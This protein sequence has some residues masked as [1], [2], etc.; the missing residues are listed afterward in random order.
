MHALRAISISVR[1]QAI[2]VLALVALWYW[3]LVLAL[4]NRD[5]GLLLYAMFWYLPFVS[6]IFAGTMLVSFYR[7][8]R[9]SR[10]WVRSAVAAAVG[11]LLLV[12]YVLLSVWVL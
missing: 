6:A 1:S 4:Q 8:G 7:C 11:P 9:A 5:V 2:S 3:L 10:W 12:L